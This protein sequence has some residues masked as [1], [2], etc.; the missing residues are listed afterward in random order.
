MKQLATDCV[1]AVYGKID[2]VKRENCFE[3]FGL[4]FMIDDNNKVWL[5][6]VN[7][8]PCLA[9]SSSLLARIIPNMIE[10]AIRIAID[11]I[12]PPP[13]YEEWPF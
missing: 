12:Y 8:N 4:D 10:N 3:I 11:P 1:R 7:T 6:E 2:P 13:P 5:I 9:L